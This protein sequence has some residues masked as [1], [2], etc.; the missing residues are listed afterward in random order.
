MM[1]FVTNRDDITEKQFK[2]IVLFINRDK[3]PF[4]DKPN[5]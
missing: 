4:S 2:N 3:Y 5:E 1:K